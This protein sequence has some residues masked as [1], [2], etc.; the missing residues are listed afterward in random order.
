MTSLQEIKW[1]DLTDGQKEA[2]SIFDIGKGN[3]QRYDYEFLIANGLIAAQELTNLG[4]AVLARLQPELATLRRD[5]EN[6]T[7]ENLRLKN[8]VFDTLSTVVDNDDLS[9]REL[10]AMFDTLAK[11]AAKILVNAET[12][13]ATPATGSAV[14]P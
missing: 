4:R 13:A 7:A 14:K 11:S 12:L 6:A 1:T 5:L 8:W 10:L 3:I 2:L 9:K